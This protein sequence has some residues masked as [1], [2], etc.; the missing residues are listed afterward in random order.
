MTR[1]QSCLFIVA[2]TCGLAVATTNAAVVE[3]NRVLSAGFGVI[4]DSTAS[5]GTCR[6]N[7]FGEIAIASYDCPIDGGG[8]SGE[9]RSP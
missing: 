8:N 1:R 6:D 4:V 9:I 3:R 7:S 5:S 2:A